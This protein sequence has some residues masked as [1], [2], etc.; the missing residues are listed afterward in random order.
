MCFYIVYS[1]VLCKSGKLSKIEITFT[2]HLNSKYIYKYIYMYYCCFYETNLCYHFIYSVAAGDF[3]DYLNLCKKL[4]GRQTRF[5]FHQLFNAIDVGFVQVYYAQKYYLYV[6]CFDVIINKKYERST[7]SFY[8]TNTLF[9]G[10][11]NQKTVYFISLVI[12]VF[13]V[14]CTNN[15]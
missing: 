15:K 9:I 6:C 4:N 3:Y 1:H 12:S 10:I 13:V 8:I 7:N 2:C 14:A 11:S 5:V